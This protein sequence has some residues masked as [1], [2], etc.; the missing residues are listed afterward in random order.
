MQPILGFSPPPT[1]MKSLY[2]SLLTPIYTLR[3]IP[4]YG[5]ISTQKLNTWNFHKTKISQ[6]TLYRT[7]MLV[8]IIF[9]HKNEYATNLLTNSRK[10]SLLKRQTLE[11]NESRCLI[12]WMKT[13]LL[14]SVTA[15]QQKN[16]IPWN[17][18]TVIIII[19]KFAPL[20]VM[21][22]STPECEIVQAH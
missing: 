3:M 12:A 13:M 16:S 4:V 8:Y 21:E 5:N 10:G 19:G 15:L 2:M 7:F 9:M 1:Q 14:Y 11:M 20:S 18:S 17:K 22:L 6:N